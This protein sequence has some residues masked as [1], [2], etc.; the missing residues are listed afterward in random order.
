M[1]TKIA[2]LEMKSVNSLNNQ[3]NAED[4][5]KRGPALVRPSGSRFQCP[6]CFHHFAG[7][8]A[9]GMHFAD[10]AQCMTQEEMRAAS[11]TI[12]AAGFWTLPRASHPAPDHS[13]EVSP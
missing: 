10:D 9:Y 6:A 11:M 4:V 12:N 13:Q 5:T 7:P 1:K 3:Q 8:Q 2:D